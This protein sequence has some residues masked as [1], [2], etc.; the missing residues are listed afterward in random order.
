MGL[1]GASFQRLMEGV[2]LD[3]NNVLVYNEDQLVHTDTHNE[4][5]EFLDK[6]LAWLYKNH[7]K[8]EKCVLGNNEASYLSFTLM[9]EGIKPSK[10]NSRPSRMPSHTQI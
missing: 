1:W 5:F 3:I 10:T 4:H 9:P 6:V 7:L 8:I 2:L